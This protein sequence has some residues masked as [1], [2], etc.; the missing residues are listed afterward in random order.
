MSAFDHLD[1]L[2]PPCPRGCGRIID[3]CFEA[4][5][6]DDCAGGELWQENQQLKAKVEEQRVELRDARNDLL[7]VRGILSPADGDPVQTLCR[8]CA[9]R[10]GDV[11]LPLFVQA[12]VGPPPEVNR[13]EC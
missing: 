10:A 1:E 5:D 6:G 8:W 12:P 4:E 13:A 9:G 2:H 3:D 7:D 11:W